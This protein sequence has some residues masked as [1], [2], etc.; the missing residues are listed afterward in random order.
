MLL[1]VLL[2]VSLQY[3][4]WG[5]LS[6][7]RLKLKANMSHKQNGKRKQKIYKPSIIATIL[8]ETCL[9]PAFLLR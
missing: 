7:G 4:K 6:W 8:I 2:E 9:F 3:E 1:V 5:F